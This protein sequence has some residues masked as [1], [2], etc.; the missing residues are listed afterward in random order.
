MEKIT[1]KFW[2]LTLM[3]F[4]A[5][6]VRLVPHPPNFAPIAAMAL[7]G[8]AYFSKK[9]AAFIVPIAAMFITDLFLGFHETMWAVY[10]SFAIIVVIG[11][12]MLKQIKIGN[13]FFASVI[14]SVSF[15]IITNFGI[16]L[17]TPY[18][19]KTGT[20]LAACYTAAIPFFHQ[21]L[22]SDLLFVVI[23]FGLFE[24]I[25]AKIPSLAKVKV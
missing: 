11:M 6:F 12:I 8:G 4:A 24:I 2:V 3:I 7:F 13:V 5:A 10:L 1:P 16:W 23:L 19:E 17:S 9:W 18:Y 25:K 15:F 22:L 21:T 20:G 14:S